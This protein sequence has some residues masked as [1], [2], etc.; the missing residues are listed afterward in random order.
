MNGGRKMNQ[1]VGRSCLPL[2]IM[3]NRS[4][5]AAS[6]STVIND[7]FN[8]PA[9]RPNYAGAPRE[10]PL[11][12]GSREVCAMPWGEAQRRAL[13]RTL[14]CVPET[15]DPA[16]GA[17]RRGRQTWWQRQGQGKT[18]G[19]PRFPNGRIV[20]WFLSYVC[21]PDVRSPAG[22]PGQVAA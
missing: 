15:L 17:W 8:F 7:L 13:G 14:S 2:I 12:R 20:I 10:A 16:G 3:K 19:F 18:A 11:P 21:V 9:H 5:R 22:R 6:G 4:R 1:G